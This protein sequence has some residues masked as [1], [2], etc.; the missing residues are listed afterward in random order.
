MSTT[1]DPALPPAN[2]EVLGLLLAPPPRDAGGICRSER[3]DR[4]ARSAAAIT[5]RSE[6]ATSRGRIVRVAPRPVPGRR[7]AGNCSAIVASGSRKAALAAVKA[8]T[9]VIH[10]ADDPLVP[11]AAGEDTAR[12]IPG[13][14]L[15]VIDD[16]GHNLPV[17]VWPRVID[18]IV[19]IAAKAV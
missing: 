5:R 14:K 1:G 12:A 3:A 6:R 19:A 13:A 17:A 7:R 11:L 10:G 4:G 8:P 16:M 15:V 2:P 9:L 18:E